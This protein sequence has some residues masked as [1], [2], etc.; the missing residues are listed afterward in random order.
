MAKVKCEKKTF[1]G[2]NS[3]GTV[4][5]TFGLAWWV[6][7]KSVKVHSF[8][9]ICSLKWQVD[10]FT[11]STFVIIE[12]MVKHMIYYN[13][14]KF[15]ITCHYICVHVCSS[16]TNTANKSDNVSWIL[17]NWD[18]GSHYK[19]IRHMMPHDIVLTHWIQS[20]AG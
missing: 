4:S 10:I 16:R 9:W 17:L 19:I 2:T 1:E 14:D 5:Y 18:V 7:Y 11:I 12:E 15:S 13:E 6:S 8:D 20:P 3:I